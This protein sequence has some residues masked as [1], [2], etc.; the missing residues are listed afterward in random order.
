MK[1]R[2]I[3][4]FAVFC[5]VLFS[6]ATTKNN[7]DTGISIRQLSYYLPLLKGTPGDTNV[8]VLDSGKPGANL[9]LVAGT[10]GNET[11]GILAAELFIK[12]A[13]VEKGRV[14][15]I[16]HLNKPGVRTGSRLVPVE[17]QGQPDP[18]QFI[19]PGGVTQ[20]AGMEQRNINRSYPGTPYGGLA[21]KIAYAVM[22][23]LVRE[24]IDIAIDKHEAR[25]SSPIA[26]A[27]IS[28]PKNV[29]TA[30]L[31]VLDLDEIG[32]SMILD[33]SPP[34]MHGLSHREWGNRTQAMAF[35]IET[36]NPAQENDPSPELL[37]D[38]RFSLERRAAIQLKAVQY[39]VYR[40]NEVLPAPLIYSWI[41]E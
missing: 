39:L 21:Q 7:K 3:V 37:N 12:H 27:I 1:K 11:G 23:L 31:A 32:I 25:P 29:H 33:V 10:H 4:F 5:L 28:N 30:A 9:L 14:F 15:V 18:V 6:C 26:W 24:N 22:Q 16:P 8:F 20:Y 36:A 13:R 35:L 40:S 2:K 38:P 19:P 34:N 17:Y 41:T